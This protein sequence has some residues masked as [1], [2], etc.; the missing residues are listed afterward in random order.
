MQAE[1]ALAD[2]PTEANF[3]WMKDVKARLEAVEGTE[4]NPED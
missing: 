2:E 4:A 1:R 3:A